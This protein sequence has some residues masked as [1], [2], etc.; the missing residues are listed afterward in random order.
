[1]CKIKVIGVGPGHQSLITKEALEAIK[2]ARVVIGGKRHLEMFTLPGQ[3]KYILAN[4]LDEIADIIRSR[5]EEGVAVLATGDPGLYGVLSFIKKFWGPGEIEVFPGI[6]SVQLAFARLCLPW[7]DALIL[8]AHGRPAG[9]LAELASQSSKTA[10]LAGT[11]NPP[12][13]L[14]H[15]L[16]GAGTARTYYFCFDLSMPSELILKLKSGEIYPE[17]LKGRHNCVMVVLND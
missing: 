14:Y 1:M 12:E 11:D 8:S 13:K 17:E 9:G 5:L 3:E 4:N 2:G 10:L 15:L 6:S 16:E 7:H